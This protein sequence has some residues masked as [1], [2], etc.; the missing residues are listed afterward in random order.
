M[1]L[2][3]IPLAVTALDYAALALVVGAAAAWLY[4]LPAQSPQARAPLPLLF[5]ALALLALAGCG[6]LL[7]RTAALADV[8][9]DEAWPFLGRALAH[10]D[11]GLFWQLRAATWA[12]LLLL[13]YSMVRGDA[14]SRAPRGIAIGAAIIIFALSSTGHAGDGGALTLPNLINALHIA[15]AFVWGGTVAVYVMTILPRQ[16]RGAVPAQQLALTA[17][18]LSALAGAALAVVLATGIYNTWRQLPDW[19]ALGS[20][21]YGRVLLFKL[22]AVAVMMTIGAL[23]RF[24]IVPAIERRARQPAA[25][26]DTPTGGFLG[27]LAIDTAVFLVV[28]GC[29]ALLG[30]QTPPSHMTT[31]AIELDAAGSG[32]NG[33]G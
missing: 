7:V 10:S 9:L 33:N 24:A 15:G 17:T 23:N 30:A 4:L 11:Y 26:R 29:A 27:V 2:D 14:G 25:G 13:A 32:H 21:D 16:R 12:V 28:L 20:T 6:D 3:P 19:A 8:G 31:T 5:L 18:R 1:T 22:A